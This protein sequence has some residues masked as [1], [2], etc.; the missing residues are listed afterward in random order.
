MSTGA[1]IPL[2]RLAL[3]SVAACRR[4]RN[5]STPHPSPL[6]YFPHFSDPDRTTLPLCR[7]QRQFLTVPDLCSRPRNSNECK[8]RKIKCNGQTPCQ[9]CGHLNLQCLYAPN[10]CSNFKESDEFRQMTDQMKQLQ[11][12]VDSLFTSVNAL[13]RQDTSST[14]APL[15]L[16]LPPPTPGAGTI[17]GSTTGPGSV[18]TPTSTTSYQNPTLP[19]RTPSF[20]NGPTSIAFTVDVA[21]DT[22]HK[23]GYSGAGVGDSSDEG[24]AQPEAS[25]HP[26]PS[27]ASA[28][29][30]LGHGPVDP[31]W[32]FDEPEMVRLLQV[33]RE[34]VDVMYPVASMESA[35]DHMK[36]VAGWMESARRSGSIP[37]PGPEQVLSDPKTL[38]L[39]I[40]LCCALVVTEHGH[41]AKAVRLYESIQ[42]TVDK[43][44]MSG[45]AD[46]NALNFL[47]LCAGYRY[48]SNDEILAW[49]MIGQVARL[50]LELG[51]HRREGLQQI[52]D[53]QTRR[54]ALYTFWSTYVL[55]RRW[56]FSTGLPFVY[57]D[58]K[59]DPSLPYPV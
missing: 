6:S 2:P 57:Q 25:P 46:I 41:S 1:R 28:G 13:R 11:D 33:Y 27:L 43:M 42:P 20:F 10:C 37:S 39:K 14:L 5:P 40:V 29:P 35:T 21:K 23:M 15:Q 56:S 30:R 51:L 7:Y 16:P 34:E 52:A 31:M 45:P 58:D 53:P 50:C 47:A 54:D 44:L 55:D 22:L 24:G 49:R 36:Y 38:L 19:Y 12:Q 17:H 4:V 59:I 26:S 48:L 9:R 3:H 8:R 18:A 32:E